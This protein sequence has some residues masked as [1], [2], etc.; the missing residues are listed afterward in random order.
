MICNLT[1][2]DDKFFN[3]INV[4]SFK[5]DEVKELLGKFWVD[6][7]PDFVELAKSLADIAVDSGAT[8]AVIDVPPYA[9]SV[10]ELELYTRG[11]IPVHYYGETYV[12]LDIDRIIRNIREIVENSTPAKGEV[13]APNEPKAHPVEEA[14]IVPAAVK[15]NPITDTKPEHLSEQTIQR[16]ERSREFSKKFFNIHVKTDFANN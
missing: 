13:I 4:V 8:K 12:E 6:A 1:Q 5:R 9:V 3:E 7:V 11:V 16:Q 14:P 10:L 2:H 15:Q